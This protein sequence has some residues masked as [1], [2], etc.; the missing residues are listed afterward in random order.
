MSGVSPDTDRTA[1]I[2]RANTL[3][4][5]DRKALRQPGTLKALAPAREERAKKISGED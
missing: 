5:I 4:S 1:T 3:A 2:S